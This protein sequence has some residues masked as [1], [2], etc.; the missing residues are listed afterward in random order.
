M[1]LIFVY[2]ANSGSVNA[3]WDSMH[4]MVSPSTYN[5]RLCAITFGAFSEDVL[6]KSFREQSPHEMIFLHK[7]E[8]L[9]DFPSEA[10]GLSDLPVVFSDNNNALTLCISSERLNEMVSSEELIEEIMRLPSASSLH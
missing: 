5:C 1:K 4:K 2:N 3:I 9:N 10:K 7:D 6:W 8:F